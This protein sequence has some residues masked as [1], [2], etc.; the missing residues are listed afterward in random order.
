M[1][2]FRVEV[3][4]G[5]VEVEVEAESAELAMAEAHLDLTSKATERVLT[6]AYSVYELAAL[7]EPAE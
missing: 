1:P 2:R 4:L 3:E 7:E 5:T 6:G